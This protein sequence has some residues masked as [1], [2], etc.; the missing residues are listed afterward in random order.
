MGSKSQPSPPPAP[1]PYT[2]AAAQTQGDVQSAIANAWLGNAN[3]YSPLGSV[4]YNQTGTKQ[5]TDATGN[6]IDVS[7]FDRTVSLSPEQ[8]KL[9]DQQTALGGTLNDLAQ[10]Q[11]SRIS[12][13]LNTPISADGLAPKAVTSIGNGPQFSGP[14]S[15]PSLNGNFNPGNGTQYNFQAQAPLQNSFQGTNVTNTFNNGGPLSYGF[16]NGGQVNSSFSQGSPIQTGFNGGPSLTTNAGQQ[17][18]F[19]DAGNIQ[20]SLGDTNFSADRQAVSDAL[21]SRLDPQIQQDRS[22]LESKLANQG[23]TPGSEAWNREVDAQNRAVNDARMQ[24]VLA[25]GTE[26]TRLANLALQSGQFANS[27]QDQAFNQAQNRGLFSNQANLTNAQFGNQAAGQ[28]FAQNQAQA[29][30]GNQ[31]AGQQYSQ[32]QGQ[33]AFENAAQAQKFGQNQTQAAFNNATAGQAFGQNQQQ[34]AFA[35]S[36]AGQQ[37]GQNQQQAQFY[38]T[39]QNDTF[40][41]QLQRAQLYNQASAQDFNQNLAASQYQNQIAQQNYANQ[42]AG[43]DAQN[44]LAQQSFGNQ[45]TGA[46]FQNT[47]RQNSLQEQLALRNQPINEISAL[48]AGGQVTLPQFT[49]YNAP[50]VAGSTIGQNVYNTAGIQNQQYMTQMQANAANNAGLFGLGASGLGALGKIGASAV[51]G[52]DRK[53]KRDIHRV[54]ATKGGLPIYLYRYINDNTPYLG[55]MADEVEKV[56]PEAVI[57]MGAF[58]AVD[59]ARVA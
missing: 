57:D 18:T 59:Y 14:A 33:A 7:T 15:A 38:N 48:M 43:V 37:F 10:S 30:F 53:I 40:N 56:I 16:D 46:N 27:A 32:N 52:S 42:Q 41:R 19:G 23:I 49:G 17:G 36:A 34:A 25:G 39:T 22:S 24:A 9:Y 13:V 29:A 5:I 50:N 20:S 31:A 4:T 11:A 26:Q 54:G 51:L 58:K 47:A 44:A 28:Q 12:G 2:T 35:N 21:M 1:D 6:P 55:V 3:E 45:Q 8:Q